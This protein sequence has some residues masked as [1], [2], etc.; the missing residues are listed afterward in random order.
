MLTKSPNAR[1]IFLLS[2]KISHI[3]YYYLSP[4]TTINRKF[5]TMESSLRSDTCFIIPNYLLQHVA[6]N[7]EASEH[8]RACAVRSLQHN[9]RLSD[10][11]INF[12]SHGGPPGAEHAGPGGHQGIVPGYVHTEIAS[13]P[14]A[15]DEAKQR[16]EKHILSDQSL[17]AAREGIAGKAAAPAKRLNRV[18]YDSENSSE[19]PGDRIRKEGQETA[20]DTEGTD[21]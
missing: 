5:M 14:G 2:P 13:A 8:S 1:S 9:A 6:A 18:L 19:I 4:R 15:S 10:L 12:C 21:V 20:L 7:T 17:R 11:R 3:M 16:A